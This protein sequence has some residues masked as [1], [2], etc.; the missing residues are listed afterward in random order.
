MRHERMLIGGAWTGSASGRTLEIE[1]PAT[2]TV[3]A[4]APVADPGD[5]E[6]ALG[7][8]VDG[9]AA[10]RSVPG[11][12][13]SERLREAAARI[14]AERDAIAALLTEEQGKPLAQSL[15]EV[16]ASVDQFEWFADEAR[17]IYGRTVDAPSAG[18][19]IEVRREPVG[20]VAAFTPWNF[21]VM[22]AARKLAPALAAGCSIILKP[23]EEAPSA[24]LAMVRAVAEAGFPAGAI[25]AVTGDPAAV[26]EHLVRDPRIRKISL[27]GS[28]RVGALLL[29]LAAD[30]VKNVSMELGGHAPVVV[31]DDVDVAEVARSS[32]VSKFRNAGQ[33]CIAPTRFLVHA[34]VVDEFSAAFA[35]AARAIRVGD[36]RDPATEM[37]PLASA[38][39]V[40]EVERAV[41]QAVEAGAVLLAGGA[42]MTDRDGYFYEP[43]VLTSVPRDAP[44]LSTE[45]FG[46]IAVIDA[47]HSLEEALERANETEYGLAAYA[48]TDDLRRARTLSEG[49]EAGMVGINSFAVSIP[50]APFSGVKM[51]GIGA[52]NGTEAMD[53]YLTAKTVVT[54][55]R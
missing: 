14:R 12:E 43:T 23:A 41:A 10:W 35:E 26:S 6:R 1:D 36:G 4:T 9:F 34:S 51:S 24:C 29:H 28:I 48:F 16:D 8:A 22:L 13:R 31:W 33:V 19:R 49:L 7:A 20:P 55:H 27:T 50:V 17:R 39:R 5:L 40:A 52:E 53:A 54:G 44:I 42:A 38:K 46:P 21:P 2:G 3:V 18:T 25:N 45:P 37:G 30:T 47:V 15:G 32:A 11:W